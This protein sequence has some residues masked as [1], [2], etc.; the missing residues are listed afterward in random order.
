MRRPSRER[1]ATTGHGPRALEPQTEPSAWT[2]PGLQFEVFNRDSHWALDPGQRGRYNPIG[3]HCPVRSPDITGHL[4]PSGWITFPG[5]NPYVIHACRHKDAVPHVYGC[6]TAPGSNAYSKFSRGRRARATESLVLR[7]DYSTERGAR[8]RKFG[9]FISRALTV[10]PPP[11]RFPPQRSIPP[12]SFRSSPP[13][14]PA[15]VSSRSPSFA[16]C[17]PSPHHL[18]SLPLRRGALRVLTPRRM[19]GVMNFNSFTPRH[20]GV[21]GRAGAGRGIRGQAKMATSFS[22]VKLS[23][24]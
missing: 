6:D 8:V 24:D 3:P 13:P 20:V 10:P 23:I 15:R 4:P 18:C 5:L 12:L 22:P 17:L 2:E 21:E 1:R 19:S 16:R 9:Y 14:C 11:A 7:P